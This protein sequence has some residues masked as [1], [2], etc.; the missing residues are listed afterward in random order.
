MGGD[1]VDTTGPSFS[2]LLSKAEVDPDVLA[3]LLFGS[4]ARGERG[5]A[6]DTDICLVLRPDVSDR[7]A[8][9]HKR[10]D[11]LAEVD[12][13]VQ[14]FQLLPLA[15]RSRILRE[16][17]VLHC[18]DEEALYEI[19]IRTAKAWDDFRPIYRRYLEAVLGD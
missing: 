7:A 8:A 3:V 4:R 1:E 17:K 13:D 16:G 5:P 2:R 12:F 14:V 15:L 18:R 10:L 9:G 6:S 11:Y 19:A